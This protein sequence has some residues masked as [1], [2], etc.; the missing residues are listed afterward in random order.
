MTGLQS[1]DEF[2]AEQMLEIASR[3]Y[4]D[5]VTTLEPLDFEQRSGNELR[6]RT[7]DEMVGQER[8]KSL[9]RRIVENVRR[10]AAPLDHM[11]LVG[12]AGT[13]K[14]TTAQVIAHELG[15]RVYQ[16]Q[17]P[18]A[19]DVLEELAAVAE[20][21][22]VL[23]VDE[24][25]MW[26]KPDRRA[27]SPVATPEMV[28]AILEDQRLQTKTGV[29]PFPAVTWIG[30]TTDAGL[31][32]EP[33]LARFPLQPHLDPYSDEEMW[34]LALDN[35]ESLRMTI[36]PEAALVFA[37]A[38]RETP[39]IINRYMRNARQLAA[40]DVDLDCALEIVRVLN[41]TTL[42][43]LDADMQNMLRFLLRQERV[44]GKGNVR[45]Q[46]G[47]NSIATALGKSRD[48]KAVALYVEPWLI[49]QS[50]VSV[51]HGGR[52]LTDAGVERARQL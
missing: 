43:G 41:S 45:Y 3:K 50:Y 18:I 28:F 23:I 6:P 7:F 48:S 15:R 25:H 38:C 37:Q 31:L 46:A 33:F 13:G 34:Q 36:A 42:D 11:L 21:G 35:A 49:K 12:S 17:A 9:L 2:T 52:A 10:S 5:P 24:C 40:T 32:P 29:V 26:M 4:T 30:C 1:T 16:V 44:D 22:D 47:V 14:T 39:R 51:T 27:G 8:L 20:D 19:Q